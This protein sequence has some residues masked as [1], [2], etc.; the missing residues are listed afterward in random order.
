MSCGVGCRL[1]WAPALQWLWHRPTAE[2]PVWPLAWELPY[3]IGSALKNTK[4]TPLIIREMQI[5]T[6]MGYQPHI[7]PQSLQIITAEEDVEKRDPSYTVGGNIKCWHAVED[8][9]EGPWKTKSG[10]T[11]WFCTPTAEHISGENSN[12]KRNM[13]PYVHSNAI[14]NIQDR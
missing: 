3:A 10:V 6:A 5:N 9:M 4:K 14:H 7:N 1:S 12:L 13:C 2:P 8:R 11:T